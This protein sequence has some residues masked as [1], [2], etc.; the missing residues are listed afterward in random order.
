MKKS[1]A[2]FAAAAALA[3]A[4]AFAAPSEA[5]ARGN[6]SLNFNLNTGQSR[7]NCNLGNGGGF[8]NFGGNQGNYHNPRR[9]WERQQRQCDNMVENFRR[10]EWNYRYNGFT[11]NEIN[12]LDRMNDNLSRKCGFRMRW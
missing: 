3:V 7:L 6:C 9:D 2:S 10:T 4:G 11:R 1:I 12:T 8:N 5:E